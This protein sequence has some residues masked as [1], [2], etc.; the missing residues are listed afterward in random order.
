MCG[1]LQ[2]RTADSKMLTPNPATVRLGSGS[3]VA[4]LP[5]LDG[6]VN[7]TLWPGSIP[8]GSVPGPLQMC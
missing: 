4:T 2:S 5:S 3:S 8:Q 6:W 7:G 1:G